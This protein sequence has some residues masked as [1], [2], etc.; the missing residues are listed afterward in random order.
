MVAAAIVAIPMA[1]WCSYEHRRGALFMIAQDHLRKIKSRPGPGKSAQFIPIDSEGKRLSHDERELDRW[2][3]DMYRKY[4]LAS[5]RPCRPVPPDT[6]R[7][8][9]VEYVYP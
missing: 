2:H 1:V 3:W 5:R 4:L 8:G 9:V 6:P 7:P